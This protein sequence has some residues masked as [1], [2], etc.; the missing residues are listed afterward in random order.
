MTRNLKAGAQCAY[1]KTLFSCSWWM[2]GNGMR[3]PTA[4]NTP[5][6]RDR[7]QGSIRTPTAINTPSNRERDHR[8]LKRTEPDD[9]ENGKGE[10]R[11]FKV[12][13]KHSINGDNDNSRKPSKVHLKFQALLI[14][15]CLCQ[16]VF[17][18]ISMYFNVYE[19]KASSMFNDWVRQAH[20]KRCWTNPWG[21]FVS[22]W[23]YKSIFSNKAFP[24]SA[25]CQIQTWAAHWQLVLRN[26]RL[27]RYLDKFLW[28]K[29]PRPYRCTCCCDAANR[30]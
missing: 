6:N 28:R 12:P 3:T 9:A 18:A 29:A 24:A 4:I 8:I 21:A 19:R 23:P 11:I 17:T 26:E 7:D 20:L 5:T 10:K 16:S 30:I 1:P 2:L 15:L 14:S 22:F 13:S 25:R 27:G